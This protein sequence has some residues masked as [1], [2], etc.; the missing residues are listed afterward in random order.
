MHE[1]IDDAEADDEVPR[2]E[3]SRRDR[4]DQAQ[5]DR[6]AQG[7]PDVPSMKPPHGRTTELRV[8]R[9]Q[10]IEHD[11]APGRERTDRRKPEQDHHGRDRHGAW[12][13]HAGERGGARPPDLDSDDDGEE[14]REHER[15]R[16]DRHPGAESEATPRE[17]H[18]ATPLQP[19]RDA[20]SAREQERT[21]QEV[22][23]T[24]LPGTSRQVIRGEH[25]GAPDGRH[26]A[27]GRRERGDQCPAEGEPTE[28]EE[29]PGTVTG[30]EA[31]QDGSVQH[32]HAGCVHV[33]H[34]TVGRGTAR[35][36]PGDVVHDGRVV[37]Q[38]PA[39]RAPRQHRHHDGERDHGDSGELTGRSTLQ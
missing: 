32:V 35:N 18:D 28:I 20:E 15:V 7:D 34:V 9:Q 1:A 29:A 8:E 25:Q 21:Q 4:A 12:K 13:Y 17:I 11:G 31:A 16:L 36:A 26:R 10:V 2:R 19:A 30:A 37:D 14:A 24:G 5:H 27:P 23:L 22:A 38:R 39:P 3:P 6:G 33:E